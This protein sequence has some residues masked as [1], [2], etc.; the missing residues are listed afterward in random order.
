MHTGE[1]ISACPGR[2]GSAVQ[3]GTRKWPSTCLTEWD[4]QNTKIER[5]LTKCLQMNRIKSYS[6]QNRKSYSESIRYGTGYILYIGDY[7]SM[8]CIQVCIVINLS[9]ILFNF[10]YINSLGQDKGTIWRSSEIFCITEDCIWKCEI[11]VMTCYKTNYE[12]QAEMES[13][14]RG[15]LKLPWIKNYKIL[16]NGHGFMFWITVIRFISWKF[17][18]RILS[19]WISSVHL[20][21]QIQRFFLMYFNL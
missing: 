5:N 8:Q 11:Y 17:A 7:S 2:T 15:S 6:W 21:N 12:L 14:H 3:H 10:Y 9:N 18:R 4:L 1:V 20:G 19:F 16:A 13:I